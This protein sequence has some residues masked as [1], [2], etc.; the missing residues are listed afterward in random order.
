MW[1]REI[2]VA[3]RIKVAGLGW[4]IVLSRYAKVTGSIPAQDTYK[5]QLINE[6]VSK[7]TT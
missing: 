1:Q 3:D 7:T 5:N 4:V 6:Q 2:K